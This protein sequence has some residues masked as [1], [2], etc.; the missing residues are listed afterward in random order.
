MLTGS[1]Y[2][3]YSYRGI[4]YAS[5]PEIKS[6]SIIDQPNLVSCTFR[7]GLAPNNSQ[8]LR[9][10]FT[11]RL[12]ALYTGRCE[13]QEYLGVLVN[14]PIA[15]SDLTLPLTTADEVAARYNILN[16]DDMMFSYLT[17]RWVGLHDQYMR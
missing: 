4:L 9:N 7:R 13:Q 14:G 1:D 8:V 6:T 3:E 12:V 10:Y 2:D 17:E 11:H 16:L 15:P 5:G